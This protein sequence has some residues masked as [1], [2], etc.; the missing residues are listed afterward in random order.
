MHLHGPST[1]K[2]KSESKKW[3]SKTESHANAIKALNRYILIISNIPYKA[4]KDIYIYIYCIS[5]SVYTA[6]YMLIP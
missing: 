4:Y 6:N 5:V 1:K 3:N 2:C